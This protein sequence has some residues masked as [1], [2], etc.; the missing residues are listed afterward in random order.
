MYTQSKNKKTLDGV[1]ERIFKRQDKNNKD[2]LIIKLLPKE[3]SSEPISIFCFGLQEL[4]TKLEEG[5]KYEFEVWKS[6][7]GTNVLTDFWKVY[8]LDSSLVKN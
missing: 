8:E 2:Y 5:S 6:N 4:W 1:I 3:N 7:I